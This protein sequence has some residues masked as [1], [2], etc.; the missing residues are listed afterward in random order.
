MSGCSTRLSQA[1]RGGHPAATQACNSAT[2]QSRDRPIRIGRG[3][4]PAES[5]VRQVRSVLPQIAAAV[6]ADTNSGIEFFAIVS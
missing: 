5:H 1:S 3:I 4:A 6:L 2:R